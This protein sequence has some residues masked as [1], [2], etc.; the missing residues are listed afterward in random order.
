MNDLLN[1]AVTLLAATPSWLYL[2]YDSLLG[3]Q[4]FRTSAATPVN[5]GDWRGAAGCLAGNPFTCHGIGGKGLGDSRNRRILDAQ[6]L[7]V[8]GVTELY[9]ATGTGTGPVRIYRIVE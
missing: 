7:T 4:V 8:N 5:A 2:G 3:I 6:V 9:I 1:G